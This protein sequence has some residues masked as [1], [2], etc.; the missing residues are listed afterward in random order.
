MKQSFFNHIDD[1]HISYQ[2]NRINHNMTSQHYHNAYEFLLIIDGIR[3][4][5]FDSAMQKLRRGDLLILKPFVPHYTETPPALSFERF[6][7][8]VTEEYFA[9]VM[10]EAERKDLFSGIHTGV[11]HLDEEGFS[12]I[13]SSYAAMY[14]AL[15]KK[16]TLSK[17]KLFQMRAACFIQDTTSVTESCPAALSEPEQISNSNLSGAIEYIN[18]H[19]R[20]NITLDFIADYAHMSQSNFCLVFKRETGNTFLHYIQ[21]F[22]GTQAH[23]LL[24]NT[25][26]SVGIIA[27]KTG[28]HSVQQMERVFKRLYGKTPRDLRAQKK[29]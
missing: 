23:K 15:G 11:I 1:F 9:D 3:Y 12:K 17:M 4:I 28:F 10:T 5:F 26:D 8:N 7:F 27:E 19:Y 2:E 25:D 24:L 14:D 29:N 21:L 22:R 13:F 20:E 18:T 6:V 16:H